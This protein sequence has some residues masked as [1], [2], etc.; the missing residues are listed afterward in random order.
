MKNSL[1][2]KFEDFG[3]IPSPDVWTGIEGNLDKMLWKRRLYVGGSLSAFLLLVATG[4]L[5]FLNNP[6]KPANAKMAAHRSI[7]L[8]QKASIAKTESDTTNGI[9]QQ[10]T[11][12]NRRHAGIN[13]P[14]HIGQAD[15][16]IC[17]DTLI[18]T[19]NERQTEGI[20]ITQKDSVEPCLITNSATDIMT[21]KMNYI[22]TAFELKFGGFDAFNN[23][24]EPGEVVAPSTVNEPLATNSNNYTTIK[25]LSVQSSLIFGF[26]NNSRLQTGLNFDWTKAR[27]NKDGTKTNYNMYSL[28]LNAAYGYVFFAHNGLRFVPSVQGNLDFFLNYTGIVQQNTSSSGSNYYCLSLQTNLSLEY[29]LG[30]RSSLVFSPMFRYYLHQEFP[31][32]EVLLRRSFWVGAQLGY[33]WEF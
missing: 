27:V 20:T 6:S 25:P 12:R 1:K 19:S 13:T 11:P 15:V 8:S 26:E 32:N 30:Q 23:I 5:I 28:G 4:I 18:P 10:K 9:P 2:D 16:A 31:T 33:Q 29:Q 17:K 14:P 24:N 7:Q 22:S 3:S 21:E